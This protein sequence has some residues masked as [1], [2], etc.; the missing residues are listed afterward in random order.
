MAG[1]TLSD[2]I[3]SNTLSIEDATK[4]FGQLVYALDYIHRKKIV[5]RDLKPENILISPK[6]V[7]IA[8]FGV[9]NVR[10]PSTVVGTKEY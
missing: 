10:I 9:A 4:Y 5:H 8:D 7:L 1:G 3:K 6:G 2:K